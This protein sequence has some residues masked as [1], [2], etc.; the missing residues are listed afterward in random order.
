MD[1][2]RVADDLDE[3]PCARSPRRPDD[4]EAV[5]VESDRTC[6][7][8]GVPNDESDAAERLR[9]PSDAQRRAGET[10][11]G[12]PAAAGIEVE[13]GPRRDRPGR[14]AERWGF[15]TRRLDLNR[16]QLERRELQVGAR[17]TTGSN[18]AAGHRHRDTLV[19]VRHR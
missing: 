16:L 3:E 2:R 4:G 5:D 15:L 11:Q 10:F 17:P 1:R 8:A 9:L 7:R 6:P 19:R 12:F 13:A 18:A 14:A